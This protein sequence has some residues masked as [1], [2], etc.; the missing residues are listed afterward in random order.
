MTHLPISRPALQVLAVSLLLVSAASAHVTLQT[1]RPLIPGRSATVQLVVPTE[2]PIETTKVSLEVP[3]AFLKAGGRL[4]R[5]QFPSGWQVEIIKEDKPADV[6]SQEMK[7]RAE[8]R[9]SQGGE[10]LKPVADTPADNAQDDDAASEEE[11]SE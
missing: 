1:Q 3:D 7:E 10:E 11:S 8:R 9:T 2:R 6:Y 4:S 5:I